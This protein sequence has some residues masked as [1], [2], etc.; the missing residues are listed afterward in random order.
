MKMENTF[1]NCIELK[2][3][4][5][6]PLNTS[7]LLYMNN[8]FSGC[9]KLETINLSS[10]EKINN[11][12]FNGIKS[13]PNIIANQLISNDIKNIFKSLFSIDINI[14][15]IIIEHDDKCEIGNEEKCKSCS[16]IIKSNC[17]T[18]NEG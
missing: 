17:L 3:I 8:M 15:I 16:T 5:L 14:T 10:F 12:L 1:E 11:D 9:Q 18:C 6:S 2:T 7:N 4:N 13:K